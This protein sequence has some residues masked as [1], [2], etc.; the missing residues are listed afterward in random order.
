MTLGG[1]LGIYIDYLL[2]GQIWKPI[3]EKSQRTLDTLVQLSALGI[4][5]TPP[6]S[7]HGD[8][9]IVGSAP[10]GAF[11]GQMPGAVATYHSTLGGWEF[12][13][14]V[15]GWRGMVG[16]DLM[17]FNGSAWGLEAASPSF[18]NAFATSTALTAEVT[19]ATN[20][21]AGRVSKA[22]STG[23]AIG[24]EY[25]GKSESE[26]PSSYAQGLTI[27][28]NM[29]SVPA[30]V[31]GSFATLGSQS[32]MY[33]TYQNGLDPQLSQQFKYIVTGAGTHCA[34]FR[35]AKVGVDE[36]SKWAVMGGAGHELYSVTGAGI[37][38]NNTSTVINSITAPRDGKLLVFWGMGFSNSQNTLK[39]ISISGLGT[40][41]EN[42]AGSANNA[43]LGVYSSASGSGIISVGVGQVLTLSIY[44]AGGATNIDFSE[45]KAVYLA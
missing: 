39:Y 5:N 8:T 35:A 3:H 26:P 40:G 28:V 14:P 24:I 1:K 43:P 42:N 7:A 29:V 9:Y 33:F 19:R 37:A 17:V 11:A 16:N 31:G 10:L 34:I 4:A 2:G 45:I 20:A 23:A 25:N 18:V 32:S 30:T 41:S 21:E 13:T 27:G 38:S 12:Y 15:K 6:T 22:G 44:S 36:W